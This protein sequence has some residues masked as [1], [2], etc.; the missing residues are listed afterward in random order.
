MNGLLLLALAA[1]AADHPGRALFDAAGCRSCHKVGETG[2]NTGPDLTLA[3]FR[4]SREWLSRWLESPRAWKPGTL[5]PE[6]RLPAEAREAIADFLSERR[7]WTG[8]PTPEKAFV[9]AGCAAC[10]GARGRGGDPVAPAL[11][12]SAGTYGLKELAELIRDGKPGGPV[13]MPAWKEVMSEAE[14]EGLARYVAGLAEEPG[15]W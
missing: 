11:A 13:P 15:D 9:K 1:L 3:G 2:G 5:M 7:P 4:R 6:P 12:K 14:I 10:H 8:A